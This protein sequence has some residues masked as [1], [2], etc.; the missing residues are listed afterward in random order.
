M[1]YNTSYI[2]HTYNTPLKYNN[3]HY[4]SV[5]RIFDLVLSYFES[6]NNFEEWLKL[7]YEMSTEI[8]IDM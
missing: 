2:R 5:T 3:L 6:I 1:K 8:F 4:N 7:A